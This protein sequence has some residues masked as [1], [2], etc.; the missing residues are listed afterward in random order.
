MTLPPGVRWL[1]GV[2]EAGLFPGVNYYLSWC[3]CSSGLL[4]LGLNSRSWYRRSEF[5]VRA[6][7]FFSATLVS[8]TSGGLLAVRGSRAF[9]RITIHLALRKAAISNMD[10]VGGK[11]A[12]A[13]I[14]ILEGLATFV[15]GFLSFWIIQDF[16]ESAKFLTDAERAVICRLQT[17]DQYSVAG[18]E[19]RMKYVWQSLS[20]RKTYLTSKWGL[21]FSTSLIDEFFSTSVDVCRM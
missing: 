21:L 14:F 17:D 19:L 4:F 12:W 7:L 13:W 18:E 8:S 5:G 10:G 15:A 16:P 6:A 3:G 1:L 9:S 11:P 2:L 20:N